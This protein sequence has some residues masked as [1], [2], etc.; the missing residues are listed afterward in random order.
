MPETVFLVEPA[1]PTP[2]KSKNHFR[3][4]PL[5][6]LKIATLLRRQGHRVCVIR[7]CHTPAQ[8]EPSKI[9]MTSLY[10]YWAPYVEQTL[11]YYKGRYPGVPITLGGIY[12]TLLSCRKPNDEKDCA[13]CTTQCHPRRAGADEIWIGDWP[14]ANECEPAYDLIGGPIDYQVFSVSRGCPH[15]CRWCANHILSPWQWQP[16]IQEPVFANKLVFYDPAFANNPAVHDLLCQIAALRPNGRCVKADAQSGFDKAALVQDPG[17]AVDLKQARFISPRIAWDGGETEWPVVEEAVKVLQAAGYK[18]KDIGVF[19]LYNWHLP[20]DAVEAK[21]RRLFEAHLQIF[22]CRFRPFEGPYA[23]HDGYNA[24][25]RHQET[26]AYYLAPGWTDN[27]V[28]EFRRRCRAHN[29]Y[30]R[31]G[32]TID[33]YKQWLADG[34]RPRGTGH[35][36][37]LY[38]V[39]EPVQ[40]SFDLPALP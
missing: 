27:Q 4:L 28:R 14:E 15:H 36:H 23:T 31:Y 6:L 37:R 1:W 7:G 17:I 40:M 16:Q 35:S 21:R 32:R 33:E 20:F 30:I 10:T 13:T 22:D 5:S 19:C 11:R 34:G 9:M 8:V 3:F 26:G 24:R 18:N 38:P 12:A 29:I 2:P 25:A 39:L